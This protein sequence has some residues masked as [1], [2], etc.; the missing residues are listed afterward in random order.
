LVGTLSTRIGGERGRRADSRY[1]EIASIKAF[2]RFVRH[3]EDPFMLL[4]GSRQY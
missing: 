2:P 3:G 1:H 4:C